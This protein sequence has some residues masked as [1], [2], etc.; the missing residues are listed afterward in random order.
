M[1]RLPDTSPSPAFVEVQYA[2]NPKFFGFIKGFILLQ[3]LFLA[4]HLFLERG[5]I[6]G[7]TQGLMI[8]LLVSGLGLFF[9]SMRLITEINGEGISVRYPPFQP[10][11]VHFPWRTIASVELRRY[12]ALPEYN[13]WGIKTGISGRSYT[14][15]GDQGIQLQLHDGTRVLIGTRFPEYV[16]EQ[17][18]SIRRTT[19]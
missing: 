10:K 15:K 4:L 18:Q 3:I 13:G 12:N 6:N 19:P 5:R 1:E 7:F 11:R 8:T 14:I 16:W 17:I 9:F 2:G